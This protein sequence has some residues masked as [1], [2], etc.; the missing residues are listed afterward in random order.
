MRWG[1]HGRAGAGIGAVILALAVF[2]GLRAYATKMSKEAAAIESTENSQNAGGT[3][4]PE[5][6]D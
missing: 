6:E 3:S 4:I 2:I 5:Q 1:Q